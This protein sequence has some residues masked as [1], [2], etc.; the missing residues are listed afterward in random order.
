MRDINFIMV[1][2]R[3]KT[4]FCALVEQQKKD[5]IVSC[6]LVFD[7]EKYY[8]NEKRNLNFSVRSRCLL[9]NQIWGILYHWHI[10][11]AI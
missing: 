2:R 11:P 9:H 5:L 10:C 1:M 7:R 8:I 3:K 4:Y 6:A